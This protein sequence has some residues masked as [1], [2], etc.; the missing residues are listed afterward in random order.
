MSRVNQRLLNE[1][2]HRLAPI[3]LPQPGAKRIAL[4]NAR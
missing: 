4:G 1:G 3:Q 2:Q